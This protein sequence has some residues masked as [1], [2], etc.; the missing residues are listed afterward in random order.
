MSLGGPKSQIVNNAID[1]A[2][3][4]GIITVVAAG[5]DGIDACRNSPG[6]SSSSITV[7]ATNKGDYVPRFSN[8]GKCVSILAPGVDVLGAGTGYKTQ[9]KLM[10]GTSMATPHVTGVIASLLPLYNCNINKTLS[11]LKELAV[12]GKLKGVVGATPNKLLQTIK[13]YGVFN[14]EF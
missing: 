1:A 4:E 12:S 2:R 10:T 6:S 5:N 3:R 13:S 9:T 14:A 7:G 11:K 8:W